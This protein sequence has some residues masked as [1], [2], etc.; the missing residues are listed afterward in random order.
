MAP[1]TPEPAAD[2]QFEH[3]TYEGAPPGVTCGMCTKPVG[4]EYWQWNGKVLCG[5]C[6]GQVGRLEARAMSA[7]T[8]AKAAAFGGATALGCGVAY[9]V[10]ITFV[11]MNLS[12]LTIGIGYLVA[13]AIR[14]PTG[15]VG[16]R[17][18]QV[19][20]VALTYLATAL[21]HAGGLW[22]VIA[23]HDVPL[24]VV[25]KL[26]GYVLAA[27][28]QQATAS[29]LSA[30]ITGFGLLEAWRRTR[31]IP[32]AVSGPYRVPTATPTSP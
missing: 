4:L 12:L 11:H 10:F 17:Q 30:L 32:M 22:S 6:R 21:G 24:S 20:A 23:D 9:A 13:T 26:V 31:P 14:K 2:L 15:N 1:T 29:P 3:A 18:Y 25:P 16:G 8:F 5:S 19:L 28:V 7:P 27:P